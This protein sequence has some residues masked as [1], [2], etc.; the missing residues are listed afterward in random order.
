MNILEA[1]VPSNCDIVLMSD[2]HEGTKLQDS[3]GVKKTIEDVRTGKD[4]FFI[5][6]GDEI[7]AITVDDKRYFVSD[8]GQLPYNQ[9]ET[10]CRQ[11]APIKSRCLTWL[12][13]N[14]PLKL[15]KF[16]LLTRD[17]LCK[18]L[19]IPYG[20]YS[21]VLKLK[22]KHGP[23]FKIFLTHGY[24]KIGTSAWD[25]IRRVANMRLQLKNMLMNKVGDCLVMAMGHTHKLL[26]VTPEE[27]LYIVEQNSR[28]RQKYFAS[29]IGVDGFIHP[30]H[31]FYVNSGSYVKNF[32]ANGEPSGY[33]ETLGLDPTQLG[34]AKLEIRDRAISQI[35]EIHV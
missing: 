23:L 1:T 29:A 3:K 33:A 2:T 35:K 27:W 25:P 4:T 7:E 5:H 13:G 10:V 30:D 8:K 34:F 14:H 24:R 20:T 11:F 26:T 6:L 15:W 16:G 12:D 9:M 32:G 19:S 17:K 21:C 28:L 22:D 31:R 18:E